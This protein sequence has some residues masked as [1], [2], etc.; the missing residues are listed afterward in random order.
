MCTNGLSN[1]RY[2]AADFNKFT[3][4]FVFKDLLIFVDFAICP[5]CFVIQLEGLNK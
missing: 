3:H 4:Q 2:T 5:L 1:P